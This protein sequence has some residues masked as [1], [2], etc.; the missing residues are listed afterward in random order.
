MPAGYDRGCEIHADYAVDREHQRSG[1]AGKYQGSHLMPV[2]VPGRS[3]PSE[4]QHLVYRFLKPGLDLI[5]NRPDIR[6]HSHIPE[7]QRNGEIG[8][9]GENIPDQGRV[10][11][12]PHAPC[13]WIGE[14]VKAQQGPS[15]VYDREQHRTD[16]RKY[17]HGF[18]GPVD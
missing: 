4:T 2:P 15:H 18:S 17:G 16:H 13:I 9:N 12:H 8:R 5:A 7:N 14:N 11:I 10:E 1:Q 6:D 3:L